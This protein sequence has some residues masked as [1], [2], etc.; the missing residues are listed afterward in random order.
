MKKLISTLLAPVM[1]ASLLAGCGSTAKPAEEAN[2]ETKTEAVSGNGSSA[3]AEEK[4]DG[5]KL[6][7]VTTIFPEYDW[8]KEILGENLKN[9]DLTMLLDNGVDLHSYQPTADDIVKISTSDLFIYVGGES[10]TWVEDA[11]KESVNKDMKVINLLE[12]LGDSVKEE[13]VVEGMEAEHDHHHDHSK[14]VSTFE[15]NEVQDRS[16]S[17]WEGEWKSAYP[18][19][20]DG[21][22]DEAF[23]A[24]AASGKMTAEEYKA[25][26]Q[27]GYE[28]DIANM[29]IKGNTISYSYD[30]GET[31]SA[32]YKY[33]GYFI[34]NW[35]GGTKA[36]MYRFESMNPESKAP[37]YIEINDHM[38]GPEKAEHF[39]FRMSDE[40]FEAIEDPENR[41]PTFF[42]M[43]FTGEEIC[44]DL[45][46]HDHK[47]EEEEAE[48]DE[49][50]WLSLKN[51]EQLVSAISESLCEIDAENAES[52]KANTEA[53]LTKLDELDKKYQETVDK[54]GNKTVL[55][56]DRFPFRYLVDD[57]GLSYYAAFVGCS[58]ETE[59]SFE[60]I[61]F[62]AQKM[63]ELKLPAVLTIEGDNHKIAETINGNT[64]AQ[65]A[66]I[67]TMDS[68]QATTSKDV[69]NG[70]NYLD[71]MTKNLDVLKTAL[72]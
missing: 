13:E 26:Y 20:L 43:D 70:A 48:Y 24:K 54:A 3:A 64:K 51:A 60:T 71:I 21:S 23:E 58:A 27:K 38:I 55:F 52:Y 44:E 22:L 30:N 39:H 31:V 47:H 19:A 57:Y 37:K 59:A 72:S 11:L 67:L 69:E 41:W 1:L 65:S 45:K 36:A 66:E 50:V 2:T 63:D 15:D 40:S 9:V 10:D 56:G 68:M 29:E 12:T 46:G 35:S 4:A 25:Y 28:T 8:V 53:Y 33:V 42:P 32:E 49:H 14:E 61:S 62:L 16:I 7:I 18:Y 5:K 34:Q 6:N 17:D